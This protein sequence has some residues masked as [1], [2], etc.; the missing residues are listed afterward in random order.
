MMA[1]HVEENPAYIRVIWGS[2]H[3]LGRFLPRHLQGIPLRWEQTLSTETVYSNNQ[4][5]F[6]RTLEK[7]QNVITRNLK[8]KM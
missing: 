2:S 3:Q 7:G 8:V 6:T 5:K 1:T 4:P